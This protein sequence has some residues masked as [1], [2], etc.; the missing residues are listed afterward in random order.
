MTSLPWKVSTLRRDRASCLTNTFSKPRAIARRLKCK[1]FFVANPIWASAFLTGV[2]RFADAGIGKHGAV[3]ELRDQSNAAY[4]ENRAHNP[5]TAKRMSVHAEPAEFI[6]HQRHED[7][8]RNCQSGEWT[9][10]NLV[11]E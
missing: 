11:Y 2:V 6:D 8:G 7:I 4:H 3:L 1:A 9:G 5:P 10:S